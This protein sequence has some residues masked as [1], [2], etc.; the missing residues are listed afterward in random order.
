MVIYDFFD[1]VGYLSLV[2]YFVLFMVFFAALSYIVVTMFRY[3]LG[4]GFH[5]TIIEYI[6]I[7]IAVLVPLIC[8]VV[9]LYRTIQMGRYYYLYNTQNY[10]SV[11]GII[12]QIDMIR[13]DYRA[14]E[15]YDVFFSVDNVRFKID[16]IDK[17]KLPQLIN[18]EGEKVTVNYLEERNDVLVY[19]VKLVD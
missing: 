13:N 18:A 17:E 14:E 7:I 6:L 12:S 3:L 4:A 2:C 9:F 8:S 15:L 19:T 11:S 1:Y 5:R 10:S 16:G